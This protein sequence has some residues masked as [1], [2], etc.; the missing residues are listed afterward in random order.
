MIVFLIS[1]LKIVILLGFL[2]FIHELGHFL[3]AKWCKV[4][5]KEFAIGFGPVLFSKQGKETKYQIRAIPLGGFVS[6]E[7][8]EE[9]SEEE[10]AFNK[11]SIPKRI[12]IVSAGGLVNIIF[13]LIVY[14]GLQTATPNNVTT[15]VDSCTSGYSAESVGI[16][17][18]DTIKKINGKSVKKQSDIN[19]IINSSNGEVVTIQIER[20]GE[21]LEYK[22]APTMLEYN[23]TGIYLEAE[24]STKIQGF[25]SNGN[26]QNQGLEIGDEIISVNGVNIENNPTELSNIL[27]NSSN[28]EKLNFTVKRN[29]E[30][31]SIDI[32]PIKQKKY[33]LGVKLKPADKNLA[34]NIYYAV[35]NT[36]DFA[37]SIVDNIKMLFTGR[38][39]TNDLM[40]P[41]GISS[42]VAK[43]NGLQE[44]I[45]ILALIS[46]SLGVTNLLPFPPLDG[47]KIVLLIIEAIRRKPLDEKYEM[48]IQMLGFGLMI[49]LSVYVT[50]NDIHRII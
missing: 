21:Q 19:K 2:V 34:N 29:N 38:V 16:M 28:D 10:G 17:P 7:G 33:L 12:A 27:K 22:T 48:G 20:N 41:V 24:N 42:V 37:F 47:G 14:M 39:S 6:M 40:G 11:V 5:V 26:V 46:L 36:G 49:L 43:T 18:G 1:V 35:L 4:K 13:A 3:I 15:T 30:E 9:R 8:E 32:T 45:Y 23:S 44:F 25:D 50:F 31:L